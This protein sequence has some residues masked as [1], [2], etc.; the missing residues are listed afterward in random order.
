M[1]LSTVLKLKLLSFF[2]TLVNAGIS[3]QFDSESQVS[4]LDR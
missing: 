4:L 1:Y 3:P 2:P